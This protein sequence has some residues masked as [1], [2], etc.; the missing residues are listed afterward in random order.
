MKID[1][2]RRFALLLVLTILCAAAVLFSGGILRTLA[3]VLLVFVLPGY[4]ILAAWFPEQ[5]TLASTWVLFSIM[6]SAA[7][8]GLGGLL[9]HFTLGLNTSSWVVWLTTIIVIHSGIAFVRQY[10]GLPNYERGIPGFHWG[11]IALIV[12]GMI[13]VFGA[14]AVARQ[15]ILAQSRASFTQLWIVPDEVEPE[16]RVRIGVRNLENEAMAYRLVV[17]TGSEPIS[18]QNLMIETGQVWE[19]WLPVDAN[20]AQPIRVNL[21]RL[22]RPQEIYR[23]VTQWTYPPGIEGD[24]DITR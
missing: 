11:Q 22:D 18:E 2:V 14:I 15:G 13:V 7:V 5:R 9:L 6:V 21:Y 12:V 20:T 23:S 4:T 19:G 1:D 16:L 3:A 24:A 10:K 17:I 8:T